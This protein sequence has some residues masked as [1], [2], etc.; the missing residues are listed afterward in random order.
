[1]NYWRSITLYF[2]LLLSLWMPLFAAGLSCPTDGQSGALLDGIIG[3]IRSQSTID[4]ILERKLPAIVAHGKNRN[5]AEE[6][7]WPNL[8]HAVQSGDGW[9]TTLEVDAMVTRDG[10][11]VLMHDPTFH[12]LVKDYQTDP[13]MVN[14]FQQEYPDLAKLKA[15][16]WDFNLF[17]EAA[18]YDMKEI[19]ERF[20]FFD[21]ASGFEFEPMTLDELLQA[22]KV[23][24]EFRVPTYAANPRAPPARPE[25]RASSYGL[26]PEV[27]KTKT[28]LSLY[29][30]FKPVNN[31]TR[32]LYGLSDWH[33][34]RTSW[35]DAQLRG[36][37]RGSIV[38]L[39]DE[40]KLAK[41]HDKVFI[42]VRHPEIAKMTKEVDPKIVTMASPDHV[43]KNF[44]TQEFIKAVEEFLPY[45]PKIVEV[46]YLEHILDPTFRAWA[47]EKKLKIFFNQI[48]QVDIR[49]FEGI[50]RDNLAK[51]LDDLTAPGND[52]LL[53]TNSVEE[54]SKA[55]GKRYDP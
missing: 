15:G 34:I 11:F 55:F 9:L 28:P 45:Q 36:F 6:G 14:R 10:K 16:Q 24:G 29:I 5:I 33:W 22:I 17:D 1:M 3:E 18:L 12:R 54:L 48:E 31:Y 51:L 42:A 25:V 19:K 26:E 23:E 52:L 46:K 47:K 13:Q 49:Q 43:T 53:Q 39:S 27:I 8:K 50:Y 35:S 32:R 40:L 41:A 21:E 2:V 30:D 20:R 38:H 44:S 37:T 4:K 7:T